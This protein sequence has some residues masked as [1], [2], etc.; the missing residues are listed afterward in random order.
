MARLSA[1]ERQRIRDAIAALP[2]PTRAIYL[3]HLLDGE[4]Y[5]TIGLRHGLSLRA[6][7]RHIADAIVRIDRSVHGLEGRRNGRGGGLGRALGRR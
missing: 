5:S 7:E 6:V 4:D 2:E 3:A 1:V